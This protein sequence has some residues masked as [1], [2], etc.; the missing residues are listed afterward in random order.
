[1]HTT[2][3]TVPCTSM[4]RAGSVPAACCSP[5]TFWVMT[6]SS[7]P[8]RSRSVMARWPALGSA[9]QAGCSSRSRHARRRTCGI[10]H[11]VL[12]RGPLLGLGVAGPHAVRAAEVG[13]AAVGADAGAGQHHD[14]LALVDPGPH[15]LDLALE[16][17]RGRRDRRVRR[18]SSGSSDRR[19]RRTSSSTSSGSSDRRSSTW[20]V[21][22]FGMPGIV[23]HP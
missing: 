8:L 19:A 15:P 23:A 4:T 22:L 14:V 7:L 6:R 12:Q 11:V 10:G 1:M 13:D 20:I 5:S 21:E 18:P 17:R 9:A 3:W 2:S 16:T